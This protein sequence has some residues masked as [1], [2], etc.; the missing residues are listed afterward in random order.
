MSE[1]AKG[2]TRNAKVA[3]YCVGFVGFMIGMAYA[4]VPLYDLFCRVTGFGG[5]TQ[6]A[7]EAPQD[8]LDR[9]ITI[10]FDA[11]MMPG[12][13]WEFAPETKTVTARIGETFIV[14]Y[15]AENTRPHATT[16]TS[17]FNVTPGQ[18]G[19]YF[20]K[21]QCFCFTEQTLEPGERVVMP[22]QFFV[23]PDAVEDAMMDGVNTITLSYTFF[24]VDDPNEDQTKGQTTFS[25]EENTESK[26]FAR[27]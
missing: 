13:G 14:N 10:R 5:T 20:N 27:L 19:G 9:E 17:T 2:N 4:A 15:I 12:L 11:N 1:N 6:I 24:K 7:E 3:F 18:A 26:D 8:I 23:S 25:I 16:G 22:V 21:M